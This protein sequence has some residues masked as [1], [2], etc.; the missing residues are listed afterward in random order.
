MTTIDF[1]RE[2]NSPVSTVPTIVNCSGANCSFSV[3]AG[4]SDGD[5]LQY[6]LATG[7]EDGGIS[8][9]A[10]LSINATTGVVSWNT[11]GRTLGFYSVQ[12]V[13]EARRN[14]NLISQVAVDFLINL[15]NAPVGSPPVF[16]H[17]GILP[18]QS[19]LLPACN[20][21]FD[22]VANKRLGFTVRASDID[23]NST[24]VLNAI[25]LPSGATTTPP[26]PT[27][28]NPVSTEFIWTPTSAQQGSHVVV[29]TAT[30]NTGLQTQCSAVI[31]VKVDS[32]GD[33][34]PDDWERSGYTYNG[35]FV[36]LPAMDADPNHKDIFVQV[37]YLEKRGFLGFFGHNHRF[38]QGAID[39]VVNAFAQVPNSLFAIPNPDGRDGITLHIQPDS[40]PIDE[41]GS[42]ENLGTMTL[43]RMSQYIDCTGTTRMTN[44]SDYDWTAFDAIK[45]A[46]FNEAMSLSH[47]YVIFGH[48]FDA[49][50]HSGISRGTPSSD[51]LVT[52]GGFTGSEGT[53]W[54][55][56][57]TF[58][59]ELGHNLG[60]HHGGGDDCNYK[61]NY[62]S[63]MNYL[64]QLTGLQRNGARGNFDYSRFVLPQL[65]EANLNENVGLNGGSAV[66]SYGT[67]WYC[68]GQNLRDPP[69]G[70]ANPVNAPTNWNCVNG[71]EAMVMIDINADSAQTTLSSFNDWVNLNF[72]GGLIGAGI[73]FAL[74]METPVDELTLEEAKNIFPQ[75]PVGLAAQ[76]VNGAVQLTWNAVGAP[77]QYSYKIYRSTGGG[78]FTV[79]LTTSLTMATD[80]TVKSGN[81]YTYFVTTLSPPN[82]EGGPSN[83]ATV[84]LNSPPTITPMAQAVT[85][86]VSA[87][88]LKIATVSDAED[89]AGTLTVTVTSA[90][91]S[92]GVTLS[93]ITNTGGMIFANVA[94]TCGFTSATFTLKV[95][96]S[97]GLMNTNTLTITVS[98]TQVP[99]ITCPANIV[100]STDANQCT[101]V[102]TFTATATD[103]CPGVTVACTPASGTAFPKG[104]TTVTCTATDAAGLT[105]SC[106]FTVTVNDTQAPTI[107]CP[108]NVTRAAAASQ[109][110]ANVSFT[111][112]ASDNC[113]A[114]PTIACTPASGTSFAVGTTT[115]T[116]RA[117]DAA[118]NQST[119][120]SFTVT[121][122][123][124]QAP[125][126]AAC[127]ANINQT[128]PGT[129]ATINYTPPAATDNCPGVTVACA[130]PSGSSF[131]VGT[132]TV[133]C[134]ATDAANNQSAVCS[135][136]VQ[137][138][139]FVPA[140]VQRLSPFDPLVC[141]AP[142]SVINGSFGITNTSAIAQTGTL[143]AALPPQLIPLPG[144]CVVNT[145]TCSFINANTA[146]QWS[147]TLTPG[148]TVNVSYQAQIAD[149]TPSG[150]QLCA[151]TTA[152]FPPGNPASIQVCTTVTCPP[153]GPGAAY[154]AAS[155]VSD[156]RA[157]SVLVFNLYTS[158]AANP[159]RQ[160]TRLSVTNTDATRTTFVHLFF[161]EGATCSVADSYICLTP[162]Q[163]A[164]FLAAD[165]D[166]GATG[167][168]VAVAVDARGCPISF[169]HLVGDEFVKLASGHAANLG[170]EAFGALAGGLPVCN[171]TSPTA[172]LNFDGVSYNLAPRTLALSN[173]GS[174]AA[175]NDTL[176]VVNRLGGN[177]ATGAATLTS[178]FG[179]LYD[180]AEQPFSF[181]F[182]PGTCQFRSALTSSFPRTVP[183]LEQIIPAGRSGWLKLSSQNDQALLGAALNFNANAA[184]QSNAFNQGHNLHKLTLTNTASLT[185]PVFPPRC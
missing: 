40:T 43:P 177:L 36:N 69:G 68:Q 120:C 167:F 37:S 57:G 66:N 6:R 84:L 128:I 55:Q 131:N 161:V 12:V 32:D 27:S 19:P 105:A 4:D 137:L 80:N 101:A 156:Q 52:L 15:T 148:Q 151:V 153:A 134:R 35:T 51:L 103:N 31:D 129:T 115:V 146:V 149:G 116:C 138:T 182:S 29:F 30:D 89:A 145:G 147:G 56:A 162:N 67:V 119:A 93:S 125:V 42:N 170:A 63:I 142:G 79:I 152:S 72:K 122:N 70:G 185:I 13:I 49:Q 60:L 184:A 16:V 130:P 158:D 92:N 106:S 47:H 48:R 58:M 164:S 174:R 74:E 22:W 38:R 9:P 71:I 114:V 168:I 76:S 102:T 100:K 26:V 123:D 127:P 10:G 169:N 183:R 62:L 112:T 165:L 73:T 17:T 54:D 171:D 5:T 7:T 118:G 160:N 64:F 20:Q 44:Q 34:L 173:L 59:H 97:G 104:V 41:D 154:A 46:R 87:V 11:A 139:N 14:N 95:T 155:P 90:N 94:A 140:P 126:L 108:A 85:P 99:V 21:T 91:P 121:V 159:Q 78:S 8:Q 33:G 82:A 3:P 166:P 98:D 163:T 176:L 181:S 75:A 23:A 157:G 1:S 117:T 135:F 96:D 179:V 111:P 180:D 28:G 141:N 25:G 65:N 143:T 133:T 53:D 107:I 124:T 81:T 2:T 77:N 150:T 132:T 110:A 175:G 178:L 144:S 113:T 109:C 24:V 86:G 83:T 172:Q 61:P 18:R 136:T 88:N 45:R 50:G 39:I